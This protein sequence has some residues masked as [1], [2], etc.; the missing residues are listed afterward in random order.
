LHD[1]QI[2]HRTKLS[3]LIEERYKSEYCAMVLDIQANQK[4]LG[5]VS[6]TSDLWSNQT[7]KGFMG[8][9]AHY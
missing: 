8:V 5:W 7:I 2:P 9:T 3:E 1:N 4:S 6:F